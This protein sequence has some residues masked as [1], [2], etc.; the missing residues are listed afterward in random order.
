M[1]DW[2]N[3]RRS[4]FRICRFKRT[5]SSLVSGTTAT[6]FM[7]PVACPFCIAEDWSPRHMLQW[8]NGRRIRFKIGI[9]KGSNP[10]WSTTHLWW[11]LTNFFIALP[12]LQSRRCAQLAEWHTRRSQTPFF[13]G[14]NPMLGTTRADRLFCRL[15]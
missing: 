2:R 11:A 15:Y 10:F 12:V 4:R 14:S 13:M 1:P 6:V 7:V 9:F 5:S 3:G 8:R